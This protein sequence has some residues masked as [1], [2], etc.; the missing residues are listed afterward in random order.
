MGTRQLYDTILKMN[1][2]KSSISWDLEWII[3][4]LAIVATAQDQDSSPAS[5]RSFTDCRTP[6]TMSCSEMEFLHIDKLLTTE[7]TTNFLIVRWWNF[8]KYCAYVYPDQ[9]TTSTRT[10]L[11]NGEP[12]F[13]EY[14]DKNHL[15]IPRN[16]TK[17][18]SSY[19]L[20][21]E[22]QGLNCV[23]WT[24]ISTGPNA[25]FMGLDPDSLQ[26]ESFR[27]RWK[28]ETLEDQTNPTADG[29]WKEAEDPWYVSVVKW[30]NDPF[31]K[32][33][34]N[35]FKLCGKYIIR[36]KAVALHVSPKK[37]SQWREVSFLNTND[38]GSASAT[39]S[40]SLT[41]Q[42]LWVRFNV[43]SKC[44]DKHYEGTLRPQNNPNKKQEEIVMKFYSQNRTISAVFDEIRICPSVKYD[45]ELRPV[46]ENGQGTVSTPSIST[47]VSLENYIEVTECNF[48]WVEDSG[49]VFSWSVDGAV[50]EEW[51]CTWK[52]IIFYGEEEFIVKDA[53]AEGVSI[54]D[55]AFQYALPTQSVLN[56]NHSISLPNRL[57][58]VC[59]Q[60]GTMPRVW[61]EIVSPVGII[62]ILLAVLLIV[63]VCISC[64][65][66]RRR[67]GREVPLNLITPSHQDQ[68][69]TTYIDEDCES[70]QSDSC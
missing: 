7:F 28:G 12:L 22:P 50:V 61:Y 1:F 47:V 26:D 18:C 54:G 41:G 62:L 45:L 14:T 68:R 34:T 38:E 56:Q 37:A 66:R 15:K 53:L 58:T 42:R 46:L 11:H 44:V 55:G 52:F 6:S 3:I 4:S 65:V 67:K 8:R 40:I 9:P 10:T 69:V 21:L 35:I 49:P 51:N 39:T 64:Y 57:K 70:V 31:R 32:F 23:V 63:I 2:C 20:F 29:A 48:W 17:P 43:T 16:L 33:E 24:M 27:I 36:V 19:W 25:E 5:P 13:R 59:V 60:Q 30:T